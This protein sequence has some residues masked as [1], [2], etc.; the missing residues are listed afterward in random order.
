MKTLTATALT[1]M[2]MAALFPLSF[3]QYTPQTRRRPKP[4]TRLA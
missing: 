2:L 4:L 3:A 1:M